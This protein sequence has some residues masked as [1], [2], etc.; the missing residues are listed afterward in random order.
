MRMDRRELLRQFGSAA[1]ASVFLPRLPESASA[2]AE[3]TSVIAKL[4]RNENAYG[5][6]ERAKEAF[7]ESLLISNRYPD[8]E[9]EKLRAAIAALHEVQA[10]N[11]TVGCGSTELLRMSAEAC[12]SPAQNIVM[13]TPT[14]DSIG[15]FAKLIGAD[16]RGV[17]L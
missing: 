13:A 2:P 1:A 8:A 9:V 4:D 7:R 14:F 11:V 17:P 10:S 16:V 12:L 3:A 15:R 5:P 6:S